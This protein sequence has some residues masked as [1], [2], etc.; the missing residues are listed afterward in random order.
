MSEEVARLLEEGIAAARAG[1]KAQARQLLMRVTELDQVNEQ[2]WLWLSGVV[3]DLEEMQICL[4]NVLTINPQNERARK[5]LIWLQGK[6]DKP[7]SPPP[8]PPPPAPASSLPS[9]VSMESFSLQPPSIE[10]QLNEEPDFFSDVEEEEEQEI[11][12]PSNRIPCPVCQTLNYDLARECVKCGF[13]LV[14]TCTQCGNLVPTETGLCPQCGAELPLPQKLSGVLDREQ[15]IEDLYRE[16]LGHMQAERHQEA[17]AAFEQVLQVNPDHLEAL[18]NLGEACAKLGLRE[19]AQD[20]W[21]E[22]KTRQPDHPYVDDALKSLIPPRERRRMAKET[23]RAERSKQR[24]RRRRQAEG[25]RPEGQSLLDEYEKQQE[26]KV[27]PPEED[28]SIIEGLI[29]VLMVGLVLGVAYSLRSGAELAQEHI[30]D[31]ALTSLLVAA[32][33]IV[34]WIILGL[35]ARLIGLLFKASGSMGGYLASAARFLFPLFLLL[36]PILLSIPRVIDL[37]GAFGG[38]LEQLPQAPWLVFGGLAI[39][40]GLFLL[41]RGISRVGDI[42]LWKGLI[43]GLLALAVAGAATAGL[44]YLGYPTAEQYLDTLG[45]RLATTPPTAS[46]TPAGTP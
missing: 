11:E 17:K 27:P 6:L 18:F 31:I 21:E 1:N 25:A 43:V 32:V 9:S 8:A 44:T 46:P 5:G 3:D 34:F 2:A 37:L 14:I 42:A 16:G 4:E 10:E 29:Y 40:W 36:F 38:V 22:V 41:V 15:Q 26:P 23:R 24:E 35:V 20:Y 45:A 28:M 33:A 30:V 7:S 12:P 13:P 19:Q 39:F